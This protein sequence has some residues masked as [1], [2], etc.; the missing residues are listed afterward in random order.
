MQGETDQSARDAQDDPAAWHGGVT[1]RPLPITDGSTPTDFKFATDCLSKCLSDH[2]NCSRTDVAHYLPTR[3]LDVGPPDGSQV[4]Y[5]LLTEGLRGRY[6]TL[7]HCWGGHV[8]ITTRSDNIREHM[9]AISMN[10]LPRTFRDAVYITRM[11][12]IRYLWIDSLC[13]L[14]DSKDDWEKES[15]NMGDVYKYSYLTIAARSAKNANDGCFFARNQNIVTCQLEYRSPGLSAVGKIYIRHPEFENERLDETPL[16]TRGWVLQEKLLSPRV[17][18]YGAEQ[19]Y[20]ECRQASVRQDGKFYNDSR[21]GVNETRW[22]EKLDIFATYRSIW[23]WKYRY[24]ASDL[25]DVSFERATRMQ[26]WYCLVEEYTMR[27]LTF[28]NDRLPAIAGIAK[29]WAKSTGLFYIAGLWREDLPAGLLWYRHG[30]IGE[31]SISDILPSWSWARYIGRISFQA[32]MG[33]AFAVSDYSCE[34]LNL[35]FRP[36]SALGNYGEVLGA[37]LELR[38]RIL[39]VLQTTRTSL[40]RDS[41]VIPYLIGHGGEEVGK[42]IFDQFVPQ[43]TELFVLLLH[44]SAGLVLT[45]MEHKKSTFLRVGYVDMKMGDSLFGIP[46]ASSLFHHLEAQT[47]YLV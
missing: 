46:G 20:W 38:G 10:D 39:P 41:V 31:P 21:G 16:D 18:Y 33:Q 26:Q 15:S 2:G 45:T 35:F 17:L 34:F 19:M 4:P 22:K 47:V 24:K 5:L 30:S 28:D 8:P 37:A 23:P 7:S 9:K 3:V 27:R 29:E 14:Q 44:K 25:T 36:S 11:L 43:F 13:I 32:S 42:A 6:N 40:G 1:G 12:G